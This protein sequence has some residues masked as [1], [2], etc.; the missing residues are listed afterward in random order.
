MMSQV[1]PQIFVIDEEA[2][3]ATLTRWYT[4]PGTLLDGLAP[5]LSTWDIEFACSNGIDDAAETGPMKMDG[6]KTS[7][8][9][10]FFP[11]LPI[12]GSFREVRT[13]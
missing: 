13:D 10:L 6:G 7:E 9:E 5:T 2:E 1:V 11:R 8:M 4:T 3:S 12:S